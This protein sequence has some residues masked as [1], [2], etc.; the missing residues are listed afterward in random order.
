M[1][2]ALSRATFTTLADSRMLRKVASR[3]GMRPDGFARRFVAGETIDE[4]IECATRIERSGMIVT[5][6]HLG[7]RVTTRE[8]ATRSTREYMAIVEAIA[9]A[10]ISRNI[11]VKL[12][13]LGLDIDRAT[14][15][16]N[17]RRVLDVAS[18]LDFFVRID[19]EGSAYTDQTLEAVDALW[20][21]GSHNIGVVIQAYL[22]RSP[23]DLKRVLALGARVRLVKGAYREPKDVAYQHK[24]EVDR[25]F[26]DLMKV[27]L[28]EGTYPAIA[29]HD[30]ALLEETKT[31]AAEQGIDKSGFEFQMLYGIRRDLQRKLV[32]EGYPF[33]VYVPFGT[34]WFS[35]FMR[36]LGERPANVGFVL[37]GLLQEEA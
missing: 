21:I 5:L 19:M 11:S 14:S 8:E 37:K 20:G 18:R 13:Q 16:D 15:V 7:E 22:K 30:P 36:R 25:A 23:G 24:E 3:Y 4:A 34:D 26:V 1:L 29:T 12:T 6:D 32:A 10:G 17:I 28:K 27:L 9:K 33:R 2:A 31:F 35:Y